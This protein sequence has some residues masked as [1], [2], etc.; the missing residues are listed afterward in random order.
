MGVPQAVLGERMKFLTKVILYGAGL[1]YI[2]ALILCALLGPFIDMV[3][4]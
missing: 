3:L 4:Q 1:L 2:A